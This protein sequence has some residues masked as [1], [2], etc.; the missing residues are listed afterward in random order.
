MVHF[1]SQLPSLVQLHVEDGVIRGGIGANPDCNGEPG[2]EDALIESLTPALRVD[3]VQH[4][5]PMLQYLRWDGRVP[6]SDKSI[7]NLLRQR[8]IFPQSSVPMKQV[9]INFD[10]G[11]QE[12]IGEACIEL[13]SNGLRLIFA[14]NVPPIRDYKRSGA[15]R[16]LHIE[17]DPLRVG[18][19]DD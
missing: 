8:A 13:I 1:L 11:P 7:V 17:E 3:L 5:C 6:F 19:D 16:D 18:W 4:S 2:T 10:R 15:S 12:D 9:V 14:Y